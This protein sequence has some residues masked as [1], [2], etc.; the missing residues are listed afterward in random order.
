MLGAGFWMPRPFVHVLVPVL[1]HDK[2]ASS[3]NGYVYGQIIGIGI[4]I[5]IGIEV[6]DADAGC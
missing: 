6:L 2:K 5:G 1:V 4:A 3:I